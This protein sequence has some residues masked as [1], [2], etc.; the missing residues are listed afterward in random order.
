MTWKNTTYSGWGRALKATGRIARPERMSAIKMLPMAPAIGMRRSYGDACLND[1]GDAIEMSRLDRIL[2]FD[3]ETGFLEA[4]AGLRVGDIAR[5]FIP[6]GWCPPVMPGTGFATIGGCIANDVHGK[7]HHQ[8]G[9]FGQHVLSIRLSVNGKEQVVSPQKGK[10]LFTAT[11]AGLGQTGTILSAKIALKAVAGPTMALVER[12]IENLAE[13]YDAFEASKAPYSVGW[14]DTTAKGPAMGRGIFE[15]ADHS[16]ASLT[17]DKKAKAVPFDAPR[18]ALSAPVVKAFNFAYLRRV[19]SK[20]RQRV[21]DFES[22]F[23]PL[24]KIHDWNKLYGK[25]G[26]FQFQ[27]VIPEENASAIEEILGKISHS[28]RSSP[29]AVLKKLGGGSAGLMSFPMEGFTLATDFANTSGSRELIN[30][31]EAITAKA[32]GRT[33]LAKDATLD[34]GHVSAMYPKIGRFAA[35]ASKQDPEGHLKTDLTRR[36]KIRG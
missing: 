14:L 8:D 5:I 7:N 29:L 12:R 35:I 19:P 1:N 31:L 2:N 32:G 6:R 30:Q 24:D 36:L 33:Y 13:F 3:A 27:C 10:E 11:I 28:G 15:E 20:G 9:S 34:P 17:Q 22:F 4:E 21:V 25:S 18:W 23:F 16:F 26:F